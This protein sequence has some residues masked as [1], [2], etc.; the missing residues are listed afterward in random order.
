MTSLSRLTFSRLTFSQLILAL[1]LTITSAPTVHAETYVL[2]ASTGAAYDSV[3]DGWF[4]AGTGPPLPAPDGIG[5]AGGQALA[6][7]L[8]AGVLELRAMAEFPLATLSGISPGQIQ[9]ATLRFTID[10]VIGTFGPGATFD[11]TASDPIAVY[12]YPADGTVTV[13]DF[14]PAG[15]TQVTV[16]HPGLVTDASLLGTGAL[17]FDVDVTAALQGALTAGDDAFGVLLGTTDSPTATSLDNL[18]PPGV[19]GGALPI[20][21]IV[22]V[23]LRPP[24]LAKA[25]Q[26]CQATIAKA[27]QKLVGTA[28]KSFSSCF[29]LILKDYEPDQ[30]LAATTAPKCVS[31][32]DPNDPSSKI[33][34]ALGKLVTDVE[35]KCAGVRSRALSLGESDA[36]QEDAHHRPPAADR[37]PRVAGEAPP[38]DDAP[39][40]RLAARRRGPALLRPA[41]RRRPRRQHA[42]DHLRPAPPPRRAGGQDA[43][44][45]RALPG[46]R[47]RWRA[48]DLRRG[49]RVPHIVLPL[50]RRLRS[51]DDH[52]AAPPRRHGGTCAARHPVVRPALLRLRPGRPD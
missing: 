48:R 26:A 5:D 30:A 8:I 18:S 13:A 42:L 33:G 31:T 4:F 16:V 44:V 46:Q 1:G 2:D 19:A 51:E 7:G 50:R 3:G 25:A 14:A 17:P 38:L 37:V 45:S 20:L 12:H 43:R 49:D 24:L 9:S 52:V 23:P 15:A 10:D 32:L 35:K 6:V 22:T 39:S 41:T 28:L 27:G 36:A 29:G 40:P 11:N 34:K 21:T 47:G